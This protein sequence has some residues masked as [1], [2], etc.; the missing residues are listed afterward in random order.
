MTTNVLLSSLFLEQLGFQIPK[1]QTPINVFRLT[2]E[3]DSASG[4]ASDFISSL[5]QT[6]F[7]PNHILP[8]I[9]EKRDSMPLTSLMRP[10]SQELTE[11]SFRINEA[12]NCR[13]NDMIAKAELPP[14]NAWK[15]IKKL[16]TTSLTLDG[17]LR[18]TD[19]ERADVFAST[20]LFCSS[21]T[22]TNS[23]VAFLPKFQ[24]T[25]LQLSSSPPLR[26]TRRLMSSV[27][28]KIRKARVLI[29]L[30]IKF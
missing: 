12:E 26:Q 22:P 3:I 21:K 8:K 30:I 7:I 9:R 19:P 27:R 11:R 13:F 20:M 24:P 29:T 28:S 25:M 16:Q 1:L 2:E 17:T 23:S 5:Q 14:R 4:I 10:I 6:A 15:G 18:I